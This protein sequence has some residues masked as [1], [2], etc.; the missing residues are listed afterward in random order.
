M[1]VAYKGSSSPGMF[2]TVHYMCVHI[3]ACVQV[4]VWKTGGMVR[5]EGGI[6]L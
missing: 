2:S 5:K 4:G 3:S 6:M 1:D